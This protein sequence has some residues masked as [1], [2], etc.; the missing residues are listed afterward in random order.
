MYPRE[1]I[2][3]EVGDGT[4]GADRRRSRE[5]VTEREREK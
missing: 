4:R 3:A 1:N 2:T 5:Q